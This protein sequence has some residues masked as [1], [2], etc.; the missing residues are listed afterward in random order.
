MLATGQPSHAYDSDHIAGHIIVRRAEENETL[1]LL[2]GKDLPLNTDDLVIADDEGAVGLAGVMGGAKDSIL[3][4]TNK[5]ILEI[6]DF[7]SYG[8]RRTAAALR[9]PHRGVRP[10]RKGHRPR[11]LRPGA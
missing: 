2:N 9:Q 5:V 4:D 3:P 6:A 7:E 10:L 11:A 1:K 8:I